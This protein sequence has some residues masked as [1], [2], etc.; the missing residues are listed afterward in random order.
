MVWAKRERIKMGKATAQSTDNTKMHG[1]IKVTEVFPEK[2][3]IPSLLP[4]KAR[5]RA[6]I[7]GSKSVQ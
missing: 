3:M 1:A 5:K 4:T 6:T 2:G 7:A